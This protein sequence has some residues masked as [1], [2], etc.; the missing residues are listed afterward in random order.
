MPSIRRTAAVATAAAASFTMFLATPAA[1]A[2]GLDTQSFMV[3]FTTQNG[4]DQPARVIARGP[5]AGAGYGTQT[6]EESGDQQISHTVMHFPRG[7]VSATFREN[8]D[9]TIDL[10]ACMAHG[11]GDGT[12][13]ITGGTGAYAGATG[14]GTFVVRGTLVGARDDHGECQGPD[15]PVPPTLVKVRVDATGQ[16]S[17]QA[18]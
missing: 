6:E 17:A 18:S 2:Q 3:M 10:R 13:T 16:A 4:V 15:S 5:I 7:N 8:F 14:D 1:S 12:F 11:H 9:W